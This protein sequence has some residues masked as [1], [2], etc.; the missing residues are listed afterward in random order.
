MIRISRPEE[1]ESFELEQYYLEDTK[2]CRERGYHRVQKE[3]KKGSPN[4][5]YDCSYQVWLP[6]E[7]I[8]DLPYR[9]EPL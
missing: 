4:F 8:G 6:E 7:D 5:C 1:V 2:E 3:P 9:V